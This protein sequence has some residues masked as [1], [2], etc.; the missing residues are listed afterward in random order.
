MIALFSLIA[1]KKYNFKGKYY[2]FVVNHLQ[3]IEKSIIIDKRRD[4]IEIFI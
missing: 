3:H 1:I 2:Y 4:S